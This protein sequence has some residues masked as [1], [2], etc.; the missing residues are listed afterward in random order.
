MLKKNASVIAVATRVTDVLLILLSGVLMYWVRFGTHGFPMHA[1]YGALILIGGLLAALVFPVLD[2]YRSWRAKGLW[3]PTSRVLATWF[4]VF[5]ALLV[6][7]VFSKQDSHFSRLWLGGWGLFTGVLLMLSRVGVYGFLNTVRQKGYNRRNV[8]IIGDGPLGRDLLFR[9]REG[10]VAGYQ[11]IGVF[12]VGTHE[13]ENTPKNP[14]LYALDQ[15]EDIMGQREVAEVWITLPLDSSSDIR[16]ILDR[17]KCTMVNIRYYPDLLGLFLLNHGVTEVLG[18]PMI[19]LSITPMEG[20][21]RIL[22]G[23]EDRV[24][25]LLILLLISSVM[26]VIAIGVKLSS[27]GPV[28]FKQKRHGWDGREIEI[29]KFRSMKQHQ[30]PDG[31]V[32]QASR[33]DPRVT[34][35]GAFLRRTS[36]DEL[37]QFINVLQGRMSIV[38]PRPHAVEH[39]EMFKDTIDHYMLRHKVKPGITGWAQVN[40]WRGETDTLEKMK[41]RIEYD[42]YYIEHWSL[43]LDLK[44]ILLTLLRGFVHKNA[45]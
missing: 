29:W 20:M 31:C 34:R 23:I 30:E 27:P 6:L 19:D 18:A 41:R 8:V 21:N 24:L 3:A 7:L 2:V 12:H 16:M 10:N 9:A 11:V 13:A 28:L 35:F 37:P 43:G 15:L 42:L 26:L 33:A 44:I 22:K 25:A 45:Y 4:G 36:L 17:L 40:G 32:V 39:N 1:S 38:G 14:P 5:L